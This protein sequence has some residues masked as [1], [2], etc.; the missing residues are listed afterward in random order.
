MVWY[1]CQVW[2]LGGLLLSASKIAFL[3][4]V[5][6]SSFLIALAPKE[7][8]SLGS[9]SLFWASQGFY[10]CHS[11]RMEQYVPCLTRSTVYLLHHRCSLF[12]DMRGTCWTTILP[13][14]EDVQVI[15]SSFKLLFP[16][17]SVSP[18]AQPYIKCLLSLPDVHW[19]H[20][21]RLML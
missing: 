1:V 19:I 7:L 17:I 13:C 16:P 20:V 4:W 10:P 8:S 3:L 2:Y 15:F 5:S 18:S 6:L 9:T 14:D 12:G 21:T 11:Y